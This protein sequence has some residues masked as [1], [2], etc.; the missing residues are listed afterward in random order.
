VRRIVGDGTIGAIRSVR[1]WFG[2]ML[3]RAD[4]HRW[5]RELGGGALFDV[6]CYAVNAARLFVGEE[7][8][9]VL[10]TAR[11]REPGVDESSTALLEFPG[12]AVASVEGSLRAPFQQGVALSGERG[13]VLLEK[14]FVPHWAPV[15]V[16]VETPGA[17]D[18]LPVPGAN[19]F[20][21]MIEH[22]GRLVREPA[23]SAH[24]AEDG[25][26][27]V[28]VLEAIARAASSGG[29]AEVEPT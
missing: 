25:A 23:A 10:A 3:E 24:P 7:P 6:T 12:G 5:S 20:L 18:V 11:W 14:P 28:A 27:N 29:V 17:R 1:A 2:G 9:R 22:L 15:D 19:H 21:H 26:A 13:R 8:R 4:D 16:V